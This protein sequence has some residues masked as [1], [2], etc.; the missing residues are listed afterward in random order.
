MILWWAC[1]TL[2]LRMV[3]R[4]TRLGQDRYRRFGSGWFWMSRIISRWAVSRREGG[5]RRLVRDLAADDVDRLGEGVPVGVGTEVVGGFAHEHL[6][7]VVGEQERPIS[8]FTR[9]AV[10]DRRGRCEF[11]WWVL[12]SSKTSSCS[13]RC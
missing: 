5:N 4:R 9:S 1:F 7:G 6:R 10:L 13:Q 3:M 12:I 11:I 2:V 8:C